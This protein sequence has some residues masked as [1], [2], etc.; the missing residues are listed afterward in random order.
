MTES[1]FRD[2]YTIMNYTVLRNIRALNTV[3]LKHYY[4]VC[5][6]SRMIFRFACFCIY[7][8]FFSAHVIKKIN[9]V[10]P[11]INCNFCSFLCIAIENCISEWQRR[12]SEAHSFI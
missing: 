1:L 3:K 2:V 5:L 6:V 11:E 7:K 10:H 9:G 4:T 12:E 8:D